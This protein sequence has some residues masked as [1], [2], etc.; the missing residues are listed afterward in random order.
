MLTVSKIVI[1]IDILDSRAS[2]LDTLWI[3]N[4]L[5]SHAYLIVK[6]FHYCTFDIITET[7]WFLLTLV[8][9]P[10]NQST[11]AIYFRSDQNQ[12]G[13]QIEGNNGIHFW[14]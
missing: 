14:K 12:R 11:L 13:L 3:N 8:F 2:T 1:S 9:L 7:V 4:D 10:I 6:I 5:A